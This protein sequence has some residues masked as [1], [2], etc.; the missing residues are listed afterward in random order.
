MLAACA[1][2]SWAN[3]GTRQIGAPLTT[4]EA[5][6]SSLYAN[7]P[8]PM[9]AF[10]AGDHKLTVMLDYFGV[11]TPAGD[12]SS[13]S[14]SD[15]SKGSGLQGFGGA[16]LYDHAVLDWGSL[17]G[18]FMG[19]R[20]GPGRINGRSSSAF[21]NAPA[22]M[23]ADTVFQSADSQ[24]STS[25]AF[26]IGANA[27]IAG[28]SPEGFTMGAF[29]GPIVY[30]TQ[31]KGSAVFLN[32]QT[33]ADSSD[34]AE[35]ISGYNCVKR[36]YDARATTFGLLAGLQ[37]NIP[38][39]KGLAVNPFL[40]ALPST[41]LSQGGEFIDSDH[42]KLDQPVKVG[43]SSGANVLTSQTDY[44]RA[45]PPFSLGLNL[46]YRPWGLSANVTGSLFTLLSNEV[47]QLQGNKIF[48]LQISKS[49]GSFPK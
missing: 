35:A 18:L 21:Q 11:Q 39:G 24:G 46:A 42:V 13:E 14:P 27:R 36:N 15:V 37:A 1:A 45:I 2:P 26:S 41:A 33:A 5:A 4:A 25:V 6:L 8:L 31:G 48:K 3:H 17:Y 29:M 32:S 23:K 43:T 40:I 34:C 38:V 7:P 9:T 49:F 10:K 16:V 19:A 28:E 30:M 47:L 22:N 44:V 20:L 12:G